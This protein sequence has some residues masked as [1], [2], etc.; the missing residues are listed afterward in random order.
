MK[1]NLVI[2]LL[3]AVA[4]LNAKHHS[5]KRISRQEE[6]GSAEEGSDAEGGDAEGGLTE[7]VLIEYRILGKGTFGVH[8]GAETSD[9]EDDNVTLRGDM[10]HFPNYCKQQL[11][12][13]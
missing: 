2:L 7:D 10:V 5:V 13:H 6:E 1:L 3:L 11:S 8:N 4:L 12:S 9:A